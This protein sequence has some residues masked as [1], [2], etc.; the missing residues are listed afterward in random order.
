MGI[1]TPSSYEPNAHDIGT[2][3]MVEISST[4]ELTR[5]TDPVSCRSVRNQAGITMTGSSARKGMFNFSVQP[6]GVEHRH[7]R[8]S[9]DLI[10]HGSFAR[11]SGRFFLFTGRFLQHLSDFCGLRAAKG[12][13]NP[14]W[15]RH[16][17]RSL[18]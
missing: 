12:E 7:G 5:I 10:A 9:N 14:G 1:V 16:F 11:F 15:F 13:Y 2:H 17:G 18:P 3:K 6:T 8:G 4:S